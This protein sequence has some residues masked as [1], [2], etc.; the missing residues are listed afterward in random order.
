[1]FDAAKRPFEKADR[2]LAEELSSYW[3]NFVSDGDPNGKRLTT[4]PKFTDEQKQIL[5]LGDR[6]RAGPVLAPRQLEV[7]GRY[8]KSGGAVGLF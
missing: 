3:V 8:V 1:V 6:T 7:F 4:W 5:E 2:A